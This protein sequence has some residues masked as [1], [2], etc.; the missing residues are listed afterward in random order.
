MPQITLGHGGRHVYL[1]LGYRVDETHT[2]GMQQ[3]LP[4][5][6]LRGEPYFRSPLIGQP[7]LANWQRI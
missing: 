3:M 2:A 6:L 5:G 7:I 4:S 1:L